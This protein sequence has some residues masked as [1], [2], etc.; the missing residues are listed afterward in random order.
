MKYLALASLLT[1]A[2]CSDPLPAPDATT[3]AAVDVAPSTDTAPTL[4]AT[5]D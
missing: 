5:A 1:L 4:D 2:A 3:D